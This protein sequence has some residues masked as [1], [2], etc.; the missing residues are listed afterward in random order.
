[1]AWR[2]SED[3]HRQGV[4]SA[5]LYLTSHGL[6]SGTVV[7]RM[8]S[9]TGTAQGHTGP[10]GLAILNLAQPR[11]EVASSARCAT[12]GNKHGGMFILDT[13]IVYVQVQ[14]ASPSVPLHKTRTPS[15]ISGLAAALV[16]S[17]SKQPRV[18]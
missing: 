5:C 9:K 16:H 15:I 3:R 11:H 1:M 17:C 13:A 14:R 7:S 4:Q 12:V 6:G 10:F 2:G 8:A 18:L